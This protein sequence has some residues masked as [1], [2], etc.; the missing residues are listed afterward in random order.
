MYLMAA[1]IIVVIVLGAKQI[2][3]F[4][5]Y[6]WTAEQLDSACPNECFIPTIFPLF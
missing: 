1:G 5:L 6:A 3:D 2:R 4:L